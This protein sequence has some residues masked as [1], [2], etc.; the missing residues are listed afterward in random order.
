VLGAAFF[1]APFIL[2]AVA[3]IGGFGLL[4]SLL[5]RVAS[6][7]WALSVVDRRN[8]APEV[9]EARVLLD[10]AAKL[11]NV[12]LAHAV[13]KYEEVIEKYPTSSACALAKTCVQTIKSH[14]GSGK[15]C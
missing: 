8:T 2:G 13:A 9:A 1:A 4:I 12:D 3:H 15:S 11:E 7:W 14:Q 6:A 10:E 5:G